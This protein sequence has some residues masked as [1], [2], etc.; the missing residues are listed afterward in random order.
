MLRDSERLTSGEIIA[1]CKARL[2][3]VKTPKS[4][5][6]VDEIAKTPAAKTDKKALRKP[7]WVGSER[8]VN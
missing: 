5:D 4:V 6:F 1:H 3:G 7:Y 2:G 8:S